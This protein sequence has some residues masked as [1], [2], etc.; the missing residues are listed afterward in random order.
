LWS[1]RATVTAVRDRPLDRHGCDAPR[2]PQAGP[3]AR[4]VGRRDGDE[5]DQLNY[6]GQLIFN[7]KREAISDTGKGK[8]ENQLGLVDLDGEVPE[9]LA[10][11]IR[12]ANAFRNIGA[13]NGQRA[14]EKFVKACP[15]LGYAVGDKVSIDKRECADFLLGL[16]TYALIIVA[17]FRTKH[18]LVP[19]ECYQGAAN[20]FKDSFNNLF[21]TAIPAWVLGVSGP[22]VADNV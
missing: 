13:H 10:R 1:K 22:G 21:P 3:G 16:Y 20:P 2:S 18:G 19:I 15:T 4:R 17:R 11:A 14:D 6:V 5:P 12:T 9:D 7:E 8:F